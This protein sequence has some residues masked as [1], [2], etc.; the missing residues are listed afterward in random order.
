MPLLRDIASLT[1]EQALAELKSSRQGLSE[2]E[3]ARRLVEHGQNVIAEK[4][5]AGVVLEFASY[6]K[7]PLVLLLLV[8]AIVSAYIGEGVNA[9]IIGSMAL[10]SVVLDFFQEHKADKAARR[11]SERVVMSATVIRDGKQREVKTPEIC[12]GDIIF[13][14]AG[15]LVPA[16]S[17]IIEAKDL[18]VNQSSLTG[19]SVPAEKHADPVAGS[20]SLGDLTNIVF[21]GS[22]VVSGS[23]LAVVAET[24]GRTEFGRIAKGLTQAERESDFERGVSGFSYFIVRLILVLVLF[25]FL[26]NSLMRHNYFQSFLFALAVAVGLTPELLPMIMSVMMSKGSVNMAAKGVIVK[27]LSSIATFGSIDVLCTDKTGTLTEAEIA[28]VKYVDI[29]GAEK[30]QVLLATHLNSSHQTGIRNPLDEAVLKHRNPAVLREASAYAKVDEIPFD[31]VRKR[32]SVVVRKGATRQLITK[33]APEEVFKECTHVSVKGKTLELGEHAL[34]KASATYQELSRQGYRVLAVAHRVVADHR[35]AYTAAD[36]RNLVL[37][38]FVAFL[39]PPKRDVKRVLERLTEAGIE[40]KVI[41]GDNELVTQ[42]ICSEIGLPVKGVL[43]GHEIDALTVD[44]LRVRVEQTTIFARFSPDEKNRVILALQ[45]GNHVVGYLGD[46]I[47]DAPSLKA[48]DVGVSVNTAVD[49]AKESADIIMTHKSLEQLKEGVLEGRKT[50]GNTMKYIMM[51]ISSNFGNMF[52][53]VGAVMFLPF[54]PMLPVQILLNNLIYDVSQVTIPSDKVDDEFIQRPKRWDMKFIKRFMLIFGPISSAFDFLTFFVLFVGFGTAAAVF[55]TGWFLES[56]A[57]QTLVIH[58][59][60]TRKTP[61]FGSSP[62]LAL[63]LSTVGCVALGWVIPFT[64]LGRFFGFTPIPV[65]ILLTLGGIV[66][67]YLVTVEFAKR[68]FYRHYAY[69]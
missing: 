1:P 4:R 55:Q 27:R 16:D 20:A 25:I 39:D 50:F 11:L 15:D 17:R 42:R 38:G 48:A 31:F 40:V 35:Q 2:D 29:T 41:T 49:V 23:A 13:L 34:G 22:S 63:L 24:G 10:F 60:R 44:A 43:L 37:L 54:L 61:F 7:N 5:R 19:E 9:L 46:G 53:V 66:L 12:P 65:P 14:S 32:V 45:A 62:S 57:T 6:I 51:G 26:F 59:I 68:W 36:E 8:A 47:N 28:L 3:S 69:A 64:P 30:E 33:G 56:L 67:A 18:F 58:I 21:L 52:S